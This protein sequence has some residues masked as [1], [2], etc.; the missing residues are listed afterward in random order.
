MNVLIPVTPEGLVEPRFGRAPLVATA[1]VED[2]VITSW[3]EHAVGWDAAHDAG[4]EGAHHARIV[5]FLREQE[6]STVIAEHVG[7][8][9]RRVAGRMGVRLLATAGG[10]AR[11][12]VL[13]ALAS[14]RE[15]PE[16]AAGGCLP[17]PRPRQG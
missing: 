13:E 8:G 7:A 3:Q 5:R 6:V 9:M 10:P 16:P 15:L 17:L 11:Q 2:G 1:T 4:A 14:P 12:A